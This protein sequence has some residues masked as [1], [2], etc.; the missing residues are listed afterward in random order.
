[1][2]FRSLVKPKRIARSPVAMECRFHSMLTVPGRK[3]PHHLLIGAVIGVH[4]ADEVIKDGKIDIARIRPLARL[5]YLD[6]TSVESVFTMMPTGEGAEASIK[7][8]AGQ[9]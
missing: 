1:M 9:A 6:Y 5:G 8:R 3:G 2:L 4:I 7:G